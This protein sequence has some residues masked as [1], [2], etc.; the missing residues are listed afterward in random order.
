M[1]IQ[2]QTKGSWFSSS[3]RSMADMFC[4]HDNSKVSIISAKP[5]CAE[6]PV[7]RSAGVTFWSYQNPPWGNPPNESPKPPPPALIACRISLFPRLIA[8][9][10]PESV[11][12]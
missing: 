5:Q 1:N 2:P 3:D 6:A 8:S 9:R 11:A 10:Y 4:S 12:V 7:E